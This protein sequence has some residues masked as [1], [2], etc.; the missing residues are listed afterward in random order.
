ML[1][2]PLF[3]GNTVRAYDMPAQDPA[4]IRMAVERF[5]REQTAALP[6][7]ISI[8]VTTPA[9]NASRPPCQQL[10]PWLQRGQKPW[11]QL[12]VGVRCAEGANWSLFVPAEVRVT[13]HWVIL[14]RPVSAGQ[15]LVDADL[16]TT[17][18]ELSAQPG[19]AVLD[20]ANAVGQRMRQAMPAGS[21]LRAANLRREAAVQA[22]QTVRVTTRGSGFSVSNE[23]RAMNNAERGQNV[24]V[25]LSNGR[26]ISGIAQEQGVVEVP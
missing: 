8:S 6:G 5:L 3:L 24:R 25:R 18:G 20:P 9:A 23:G 26:I 21:T 10:E 4:I 11:G 14:S 1:I 2:A 19:D 22:G 13:G 12:A 7:E 15:R 17:Q 16:T